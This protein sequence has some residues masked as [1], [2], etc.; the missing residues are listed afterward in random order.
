MDI[1]HILMFIAGGCISALIFRPKR[2][3]KDKQIKAMSALFS[4]QFHAGI[5]AAQHESPPMFESKDQV[6]MVSRFS[7]EH[8]VQSAK[9]AINSLE[10]L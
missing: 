9:L 2:S 10:K 5:Y 1:Y 6:V 7:S 4:F 8:F 3:T